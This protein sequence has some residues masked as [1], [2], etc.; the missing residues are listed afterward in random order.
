MDARMNAA[1]PFTVRL[2][3]QDELAACAVNADSRLEQ[4]GIAL[5]T[6]AAEFMREHRLPCISCAT[7]MRRRPVYLALMC[8]PEGVPPGWATGFVCRKCARVASR[9]DLEQ[10]L[11]RVARLQFSAALG[12][13]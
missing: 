10:R 5:V 6:Q 11:E 12:H 7:P 4:R 3:D 2:F 13:G 1:V 8:C 9:V